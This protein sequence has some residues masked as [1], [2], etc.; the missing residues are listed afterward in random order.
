MQI[1]TFPNPSPNRHYIIEHIADEFTSVCPQS[2]HPD[3]GT[4]VL[5]YIPQESCI[6]LKAYKLYLQ[7]YRSQGIYYEALTN[8]ILEDLLTVCSPAWMRIESIWSGR[9]GIRSVIVAE[10]LS[11]DYKGSI[12]P[13]FSK[14]STTKNNIF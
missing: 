3:F 7:T 8:K 5:T 1:K 11:P 13:L 9:G 2:G 6:E 12:P 14:N 4:I 10:Y